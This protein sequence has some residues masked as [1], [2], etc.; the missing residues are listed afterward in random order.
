MFGGGD[1]M[2]QEE[3]VTKYVANPEGIIAKM[4]EI[5]IQPQMRAR[6]RRN[7]LWQSVA[8]QE[9]IRLSGDAY[10]SH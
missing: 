1:G 10:I 5:N 4:E 9:R 8:K 3:M 2:T 7:L 6:L